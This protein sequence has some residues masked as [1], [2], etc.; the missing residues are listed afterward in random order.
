MKKSIGAQ[1]AQP[2]AQAQTRRSERPTRDRRALIVIELVPHISRPIQTPKELNREQQ[3]FDRAREKLLAKQ[4]RRDPLVRLRRL[5]GFEVRDGSTVC[6][7]N[8]SSRR[9]RIKP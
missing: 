9:R 2:D 6:Q 4:R 7:L 8:E 1:P 5:S 3:H